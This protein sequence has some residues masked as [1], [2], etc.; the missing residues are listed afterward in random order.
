MLEKLRLYFLRTFLIFLLSSFSLAS[1]AQDN[2]PYSRYGLGDMANQSNITS[3]GMGGISAGYADILSINFNNPASYSQFQT[4]LE[5]R[6]KNVSM[7]RVILDV[8]L[9]FSNRTLITP[10]TTS[11]YT[12]SDAY[13]SYLQVGLPIRKNW[14]LSFGIRPFSRIDY[15]INRSELLKDPVTGGPIENTVTLFRG[16]G[17]SYL[18]TIGTGFG[19]E[20]GSKETPSSKTTNT[21]SLGV[22]GG[23]LFGNRE[24]TTLRNFANDT[25]LYYASDFSTSTSWG[26]LYF[27]S[28]LQYQ[29]E[30]YNKLKK[31]TT[32][33]RFGLS[34][35]WQQKTKA[36]QDVLRQTFSLGTAGEELRIDSV[37]HQ[38]G[39]KGNIILPASYKAG[40]VLQHTK[41]DNSGWL[42][43]IDYSES[44]WSQYQFFGQ[45]DSVEDSWQV[46]VG[47]QF[48]PK[49]KQGFFNRITYRA[50][51][52]TGQDYLKIQNKM[53]VFGASFG[54]GIPVANYNHLSPNQYTLLNLGFEF[55]K[56]GNN[57]NLLKENLFRV[58]VG[59]NFSDL[60]FGKKKYE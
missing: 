47:A 58:S 20:L 52:F 32:L 15:K 23:Y 37:Y 7:G 30:K 8:G 46:S 48:F 49:I 24:N 36:S 11:R 50:G 42:L 27:N 14:G 13:F 2:S 9:D 25:V 55:I 21:I 10:G 39:I 57:D 26:D 35:N 59:F 56:R 6:S 44:K 28:G 40:F 51:F 16:S 41:T 34:G 18:P 3:R 4:F 43:G 53:P 1:I 45:R 33:F 17:G 5:Q 31:Q 60:W 12:S 54:M 38:S 22:N 29:I 19:F